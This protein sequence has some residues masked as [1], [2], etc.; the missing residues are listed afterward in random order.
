VLETK[1]FPNASCATLCAANM[2]W[3]SGKRVL[4]RTS[5]Y[6]SEE[7]VTRRLIANGGMCLGHDTSGFRLFVDAATRGGGIY[8]D[9]KVGRGWA[10]VIG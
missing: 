7:Q 9:P 2:S 4:V 3:K 6:L 5:R 8:S 10:V 1:P